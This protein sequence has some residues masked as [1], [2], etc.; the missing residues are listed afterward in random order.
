MIATM[1]QERVWSQLIARVWSD[2]EFKDRFKRDPRGVLAEEGIELPHDAEIKVVE[3][4]GTVRHLVL[5]PPPADELIE[6]DLM[7]PTVAYC[8]CG[9][10][11]RC[12]CGCHHCH[13]GG[14]A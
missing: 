2:A 12:G 5:P 4:T 10:C 6:E 3:D 7:G 11:G 13:C 8:W 1:S 9:G 14:C